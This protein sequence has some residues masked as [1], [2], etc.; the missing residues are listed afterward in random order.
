MAMIELFGCEVI[1]RV[2]EL[3]AVAP[4]AQQKTAGAIGS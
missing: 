4:E 1:P 2:H 3:L